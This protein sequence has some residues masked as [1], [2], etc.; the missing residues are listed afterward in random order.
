MFFKKK[1]T[2]QEVEAHMSFLDHLEALRG[3]LVRATL[4]VLVAGRFGSAKR[5]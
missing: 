3:H 2:V 5:K 1:K 4:A